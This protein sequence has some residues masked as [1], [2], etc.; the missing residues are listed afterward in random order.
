MTISLFVSAALL[1]M[2]YF[3]EKE[4]G[5]LGITMIVAFFSAVAYILDVSP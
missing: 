2:Y 4:Y 1:S 3:E 5:K